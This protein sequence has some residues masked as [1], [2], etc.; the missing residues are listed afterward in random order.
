MVARSSATRASRS[1]VGSGGAAIVV[2]LSRGCDRIGSGEDGAVSPVKDLAAHAA[3]L[4]S[5]HRGPDLLV[6]ANAWD[7]PSARAVEAAGFPAVATSSH[8]VAELLGGPDDDS[9]DPDDVFA[10]TGRI[11]AAVAVPVSADIEAGY[12]LPPDELV[13]RLLGA[14]A[15][16][17]NL[18]DTDHHGPGAGRTLVPVDVQ[19]ERLAAV[20]AAGRAAGVDLVVNAR[21]DAFLRGLDDPVAVSIERGRAYL[22]AGADCCY[23]IGAAE[24]ADLRALVHGIGG[25]VNVLA[26]AGVPDL[27]TL[28]AL[29]VA[30]VSLGSGLFRAAQRAVTEAAAAL[31][32][33]DTSWL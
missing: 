16:G 9:L 15:V 18:E 14:G 11:A 19:A 7:V 2:I 4:R 26:R 13:A 1:E 5:L 25:P 12:R 29:G 27:A 23:P 20:K 6:L 21:T 8:A 24:E 17:C 10:A 30:R 32:A 31:R 22:A 3:H 28:R 33:G